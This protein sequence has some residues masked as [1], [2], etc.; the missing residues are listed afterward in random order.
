MSNETQDTQLE[1]RIVCFIGEKTREILLFLIRRLFF[2]SVTES[3]LWRILVE[4]SILLAVYST[5]FFV[6]SYSLLT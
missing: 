1:I 6:Y 3:Y 4:I 5:V 2:R